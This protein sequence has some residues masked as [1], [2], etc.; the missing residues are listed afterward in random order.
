MPIV[1]DTLRRL[2]A[3][4]LRSER[5]D[6]TLETRNLVSEAYLR[7]VDQDRVEWRDRAHFFAI[8]GRVMRRVL[9]DHARRRESAKRGGHVEKVPLRD[10]DGIFLDQ[11]LHFLDLHQALDRFTAFDPE[12]ARLVELRYFG[13]LTKNETA[14]VMGISSATVIRRWRLARAWLHQQLIE[15]NVES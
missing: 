8:A 3:N 2:A 5:G 13:G 4:F 1:Y 10:A 14:E 9:V 6:L 7:L 11:R 12:A 15:E